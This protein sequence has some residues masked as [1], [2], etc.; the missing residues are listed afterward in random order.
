MVAFK[1]VA[2]EVRRAALAYARGEKTSSAFWSGFVASG[3]AAPKSMGFYKGTAIMATISGTTSELTGGKFA[4]GAV[5]GAFVHM[6]NASW[7][8]GISGTGGAGVGSTY[9]RGLYMV[10][11]SSQPW[12]KGWNIG[13]YVTKPLYYGGAFAGVGAEATIDFSWSNNDFARQLEGKSLTVGGSFGLGADLGYD[14]NIPMFGG[15]SN[16][17]TISAGLG[18]YAGVPFE[19]HMIPTETTLYS[20]SR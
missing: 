10:H 5:T 18:G 4:N 1:A 7:Q 19:T 20:W 14:N 17:H 16:I 6:F 13:W 3:F 11:D 8:V 2:H 12:Y 15:A 9:G